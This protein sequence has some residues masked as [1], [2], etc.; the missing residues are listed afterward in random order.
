MAVH[1]SDIV[2]EVCYRGAMGL[3]GAL[4]GSF[5]TLIAALPL[6]YFDLVSTSLSRVLLAG[7]IAG[8]TVGV[9]TPGALIYGVQAVVYFLAG[10][11]SAVLGAIEI[12]PPTSTPK[13][14]LAA[15]LFGAA[16]V[17]ALFLV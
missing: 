17:V 6:I 2:D 10:I 5:V 3:V 16:Y 4:L 13:W 11:F 9:I 14:L 8:G 15:F 12:A 7:V 1:P